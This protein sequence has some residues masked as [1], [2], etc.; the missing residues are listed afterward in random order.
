VPGTPFDGTAWSIAIN[1]SAKD[2]G[3][4]FQLPVACVRSQA[5]LRTL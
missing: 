4:T 2:V 3:I 5:L 1:H